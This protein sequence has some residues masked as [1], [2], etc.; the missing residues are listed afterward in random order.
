MP[1]LSWGSCSHVLYQ[2]IVYHLQEN[3][4]KL[5]NIN[6]FLPGTE[7]NILN[8]SILPLPLFPNLP[9]SHTTLDTF[10]RNLTIKGF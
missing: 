10:P 6:T 1:L 9:L 2:C 5:T 7:T 8:C 4:Y 3:I